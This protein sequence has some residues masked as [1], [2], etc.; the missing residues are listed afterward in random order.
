MKDGDREVLRA[1]AHS[2]ILADY[3]RAF[4]G[5]TGLPIALQPVET[6]RLPNQGEANENPFCA[7]LAQRVEAAGSV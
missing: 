1:L 2:N 7:L 5:A 4:S 6:F 3:K